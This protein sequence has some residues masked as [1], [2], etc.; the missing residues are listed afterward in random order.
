ME[1]LAKQRSKHLEVL[2]FGLTLLL[3]A[4]IDTHAYALNCW[5]ED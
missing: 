2:T 5:R 3:T 4:G 1:E